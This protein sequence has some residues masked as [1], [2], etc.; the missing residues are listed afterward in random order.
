M[1]RKKSNGLRRSKRRRHQAKQSQNGLQGNA[2]GSKLY[3]R[4]M[5]H[6]SGN[7]ST[8]NFLMTS[9]YSAHDFRRVE[10]PALGDKE[11][12]VSAFRELLEAAP[13]RK[14]FLWENSI[15]A[16]EKRHFFDALSTSF[17]IL[18]FLRRFLLTIEFHNVLNELS[19]DGQLRIPLRRWIR[20]HDCPSSV[21]KFVKTYNAYDS[22]DRT[23]LAGSKWTLPAHDTPVAQAKQSL[24]LE[25]GDRK[26]P[27]TGYLAGNN[28]RVFE[29]TAL[30]IFEGLAVCVQLGS[31]GYLDPTV[32]R[33]WMLEVDLHPLYWYY[34]SALDLASACCHGDVNQ[35]LKMLEFALMIPIAGE[36]DDVLPEEK[37]P[38][39]RFTAMAE[40]LLNH[41]GPPPEMNTVADIVCEQKGWRKVSENL[42]RARS[43]LDEVNMINA[44]HTD[45]NYFQSV[46]DDF[47][48]L[49]HQVLDARLESPL[50]GLS[51]LNYMTEV[52]PPLHRKIRPDGTAQI[53]CD[54]GS[55]EGWN[56]FLFMTS[57]M[58][59]AVD[60]NR[61]ICPTSRSTRHGIPGNQ[62]CDCDSRVER[63]T[64]FLVPALESLNLKV[65]SL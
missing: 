34:T 9:I 56:R 30:P 11:E 62:A 17:G 1:G 21:K 7:F 35:I 43:Y 38:G 5:S 54:P 6:A 65:T 40:H 39:W 27:C 18:G 49:S 64:C 51:Y 13:D 3:L 57:M 58:D 45:G 33:S 52:K 12:F 46:I 36:E 10:M 29:V 32:A 42:L 23:G 41:Q 47:R 28:L 20:R 37:D 24:I 53:F 25:I 15:P 14:T 31:I 4:L 55:G 26:I 60:K 50:L 61:L 48:K 59:D 2:S 19:T 16:H 22:L 44:L 8:A 63:E